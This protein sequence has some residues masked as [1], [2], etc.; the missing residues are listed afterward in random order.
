MYPVI[1]QRN[2]FYEGNGIIL[3]IRE[4]L[5]GVTA[6]AIICAVVK[7]FFAEK[8]FVGSAVKMLLGLLMTLAIVRPWISVSFD[9]IL[10]WPGSIST[11]GQTIVDEA[12]RTALDSLRQC[13]KE[14]TEA[15]ILEKAKSMG[16]DVDVE[17]T[18]SDADL[19]VPIGAEI[20]G[21][22]SPYTKQVIAQ[23][24]TQ[25]LGINKEAQKWIG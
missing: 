4:Y 14:E 24:M 13:I 23:M 15:Y 18:L 3:N 17:V 2:L 16:A 25:E 21:A 22:V 9:S 11:S 1:Y 7:A 6:A 10:D 5:I 20:T 8:G 12:E 19:P